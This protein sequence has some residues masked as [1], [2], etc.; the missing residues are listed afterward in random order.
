MNYNYTAD[1]RITPQFFQEYV[2]AHDQ[3]FPPKET[4]IGQM[5]K[6][7]KEYL[8]GVLSGKFHRQHVLALI[9]Y[10]LLAVRGLCRKEKGDF[11]RIL[12]IAGV[13]TLLWCCL[14]YAGRIPE[15]V[16]YSMNLMQTATAL[17]LNGEVLQKL[18]ISERT[19]MAGTALMCLLLCIPAASQLKQLRQ[20]NQEMYHRNEDVEALKEYCMEHPE[21]FYFND[22]TSMA[23]TTYNVHLW[24]EDPYDMNYMSL[25]DW[26]SFSPVW[27]E[28][29]RQNGIDSVKEALYES[30]NGYLICSFDKGLEYLISL[31]DNVICT[32]TDKIPGFQIYR[33][34]SL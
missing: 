9:L 23:F 24:R 30:E 26:M 13:Q 18:R 21:N 31:Y 10:G 11:F 8:Q 27:Q 1:D 19:C 20:Q 28:K 17:L 34:Q 25:G 22:V 16:I 12:C 15:R 5:K 2:E 32:E 3:A 7:V 6:S 29:L 4:V 33:L 14:L